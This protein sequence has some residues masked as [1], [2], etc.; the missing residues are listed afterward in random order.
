MNKSKNPYKRVGPCYTSVICCLGYLLT[1]PKWIFPISNITVISTVHCGCADLS[2]ASLWYWKILKAEE[3]ACVSQRD[4][5]F[6]LKMFHLSETIVNYLK[7]K[8]AVKAEAL[9]TL[10]KS[11]TKW[12]IVESWILISLVKIHIS[13]LFW[14]NSTPEKKTLKILGIHLGIKI[15]KQLNL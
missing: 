9:L 14:V 12:R 3:S 6:S 10:I 8:K 1:S 2:R 7:S 5:Y 13:V 11:P 15:T 4:L